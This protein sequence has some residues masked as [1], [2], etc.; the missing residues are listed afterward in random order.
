M[1]V[2]SGYARY[3][4][5]IYRDKDYGAEVEFVTGL[6]RA[7]APSSCSILEIGCGTGRHAALLSGTGYCVHG[8][9]QSE[10]MLADAVRRKEGLP[11]EIGDRLSFSQGDMREVRLRREFDVVISLFHVVSYMSSNNDL[12]RAFAT[13]RAHL[14]PGGL[15]L[16]DCWYGPAVL[17]DQ[18]TVRVKRLSDDQVDVTRIAEPRLFPN[19]NCVDVNYE[20]HIRDRASD[21][22]TRLYENHRMRYLFLPEIRDLLA[23]NGMEAVFCCEWLT[24]SEPGLS[25]WNIV[26]GARVLAP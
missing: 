8:V 25:T 18:P 24:G 11:K 16:F 2:F 26:A 19:E 3:Y 7:N 4:D 6:L 13:A 21:Q 20:I 12:S 17:T 23:S 9:D 10:G 22:V 14:A 15:F 1:T 5:L